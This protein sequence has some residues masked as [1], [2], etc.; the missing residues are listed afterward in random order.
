MQQGKNYVRLDE[1]GVM[2]VGATRVMLDSV[3]AGYQQ[4]HSAE[5]IRHQY[6]AL[7]LEEVH[8]A[9]AFYLANQAEVED[10]LRRQNQLWEQERMKAEQSASPALQR[11]RSGN[12]ARAASDS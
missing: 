7:S 10:Y 6:P 8:G 4:G 3:V 2:R 9:I 11:L 1:H 5:T 12:E